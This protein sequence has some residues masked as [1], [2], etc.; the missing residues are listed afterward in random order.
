MRN[1]HATTDLVVA[2]AGPV[3]L[4]VAIQASLRGLS[5]LVLERRREPLDKACGEGIMPSGVT[6]LEKL[7]V[8]F[9]PDECRPFLG[10]RYVDGDLI[11]E[12][13][14]R[15]G[16]GLG[17]RRL[18]LADRLMRRARERGVAV[19]SGCPVEG[20]EADATGVWV[21]TPDGTFRGRYLVGADG[22]HSRV[23][24]LARLEGPRSRRLSAEERYGIRRHFSVRPW[25]DFVEVHIADGIEAYLTPVGP[26]VVGLAL[27]FGRRSARAGRSRLVRASVA[28][29]ES[30]QDRRFETMLG[31]FPA[32]QARLRDAAPL[33]SPRG[34][35]PLRQPVRRRFSGRVALVGDAAGYVDALSGQGLE[36]GFAAAA[37]LVDVVCSGAPLDLYDRTYRSISRRYY[38]GTDLL[39]RLAPHR[40]VRRASLRLLRAS[41]ALFDRLLD[42]YQR[43]AA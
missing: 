14:F 41:P 30:G 1:E 42:W 3:G 24:R 5:A 26:E 8:R 20:W 38:L 13:R 27:L 36:L 29:A 34:A 19:R 15:D 6:A 39:L 7:G 28:A 4:A 35:G 16:A 12:G 32:L 31:H 2:G 10:I 33:D 37:A 25:S 21:H 40:P 22:L 17:V 9:R 23:R 18:L 11:A 43:P